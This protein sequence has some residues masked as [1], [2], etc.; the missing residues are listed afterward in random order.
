MFF[1]ILVSGFAGA[2]VRLWPRIA[3]LSLGVPGAIA[4]AYVILAG[5]WTAAVAAYAAWGLGVGV[6]Y[7][8]DQLRN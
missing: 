7:L 2:L 5:N 8:I 3:V 1:W 6:G 4:L